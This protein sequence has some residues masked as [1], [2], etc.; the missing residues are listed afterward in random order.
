MG[1]PVHL[2]G[3]EPRLEAV[4]KLGAHT[5]RLRAEFAS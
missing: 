3:V 2:T 5:A 4:P 1:N